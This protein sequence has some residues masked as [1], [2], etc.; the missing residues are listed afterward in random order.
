M[1]ENILKEIIARTAAE[2]GT[3][4]VLGTEITDG[5]KKLSPNVEKSINENFKISADENNNISSGNYQ[6][7]APNDDNRAFSSSLKKYTREETAEMVNAINRQDIKTAAAKYL[8]VAG[9]G[10]SYVCECGNGTGQSGTGLSIYVG[11][12][13]LP[14]LKCQKCGVNYT[15]LQLIQHCEKLTNRGDD[16][17]KSLEIVKELYGENFFSF[18]PTKQNQKSAEKN[19]STIRA[20]IQMASEHI[21]DLPVEDRRGLT[22][23]TLK[24]FHCGYLA[25]WKHPNCRE[26]EKIPFTRRLIIPTSERHYLAAM[27]QRDRQESNKDFWKQHAG[28][29]E[30]FSFTSINAEGVNIIVE[31]EIDAMSIWQAGFKNVCAVGGASNYKNFL[32]RVQRQIPNQADRKKFSFVVVFDNDATGIDES[33][34]FADELKKLGF[35][36]VTDF[37]VDVGKK[38]DANEILTTQ[39]DG[40]LK[41]RVQ[42]IIDDA[43]GRF[44]NAEEIFSS[45]LKEIKSLQTAENSPKNDE[46]P[47]A[48]GIIAVSVSEYFTRQFDADLAEFQK[49]AQ[50]KTGFKNLDENQVLMPGLYIIGG[51]TGTGKSTF[52]MQLASQLAEINQREGNGEKILYLSNEMQNFNMFSKLL[53]REMFLKDSR[54]S[55]TADD[56]RNGGYSRALR[57]AAKKFQDESMKNFPLSLCQTPTANIDEILKFVKQ[58]YNG[59]TPTIFIDYLQH[60]APTTISNIVDTQKDLAIII[61]K[62]KDYQLETKA[63]IF[64]LSSFN[65][66]NYEKEAGF[67]SFKGSGNIDYTGD[68]L[69]AL[70]LDCKPTR[71]ERRKAMKEQPRRMRLTCL[72]NRFGGIY[73]IYFDYFSAH[74]YFKASDDGDDDKNFDAEFYAA[75]DEEVVF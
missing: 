13:G 65:R 4:A 63:T 21:A 52:A 38:I 24:H 25:K 15:V 70:E 62:L 27:L 31:G 32:N 35:P 51:L 1:D 72:K 45:S 34:K 10:K 23:E 40:A 54:T 11:K 29:L 16:F 6:A 7:A 74:D 18:T 39:G 50:R 66:D 3:T 2:V 58:Y 19:L 67:E 26:N 12:N 8:Q 46:K 71:E 42:Q 14:M 17:K 53:R 68:V 5:K 43:R 36:A 73:E 47:V 33:E 57:D 22:L 61:N 75:D 56:I 20:D 55:L 48:R 49:S 59:R 69:W 37:L 28:N 9:D 30:I 64:L 60:I 41:N 44:T